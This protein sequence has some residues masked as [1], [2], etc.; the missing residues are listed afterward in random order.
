MK[1]FEIQMPLFKDGTD[2]IERVESITKITFKKLMN[3]VNVSV[4]V[5]GHLLTQSLD[6]INILR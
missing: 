2:G 6:A 3:S 5:S 1:A 4:N